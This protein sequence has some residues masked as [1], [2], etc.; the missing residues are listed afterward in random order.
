[1]DELLV[2]VIRMLADE[3][4]VSDRVEAVCASSFDLA[5]GGEFDLVV[6]E[7]IGF[8]GY[9]EL[10]V[11]VMADARDRH[12]KKGGHI[13]PETIGLYAAAGQLRSWTDE[14][15]TGVDFDFGALARLNL[16]SPRVMKRSRDVKLLTRPTRLVSTDLR[17]ARSA[18]PLRD[19]RATWDLVGNSGV[20]C[21][22]VWV[23]S[24]LAPGV[25]LSTRRTTSWRPTVYRIAPPRMAFERMEFSLSLT[26]ESNYWTAT[27]ISGE[28]RETASYS[29]EYAATEMIVA[30]R[31]SEVTNERGH[32]MIARDGQPPLSIELREA[33]SGDEEFLCALYHSTRRDEVAQFG[34]P[35]AEQDAF[36]TM[37]FE[38]QKKGYAIQ[39]PNAEHQIVLCDGIPAGRIIIDRSGPMLLLTDIAL[40]PN[41]HRRGIASNLIG[42]LK[43][44]NDAIMLNV[45][46]NNSKARHLYEKHGFIPTAETQ[47]AYEMQWRRDDRNDMR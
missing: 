47:F 8:I 31:G 1:M 38:M 28:T 39:Y 11:D 35:E 3:H 15:P 44:E 45:D 6:S 20:D 46:K 14:I 26:P 34:W 42:N 4:G 9:D 27:Y 30:A 40:L 19:L 37:Q 12:L 5:A 18:P 33:A 24:R 10:I 2:G 16:S 23:E 13:I 21:V 41:F 7:T 43:R 22:V 25:R 36:L 32:L 29:P 17:R